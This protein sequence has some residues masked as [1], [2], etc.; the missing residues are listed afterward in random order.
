MIKK[1]RKRKALE[2]NCNVYDVNGSS[3]VENEPL[4]K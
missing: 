1:T 3:E 2:R 4:Q